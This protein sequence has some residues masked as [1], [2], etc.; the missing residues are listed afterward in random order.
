MA[1]ALHEPT[2]VYAVSHKSTLSTQYLLSDGEK[3]R[4]V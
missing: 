1:T 2:C 4:N 3:F